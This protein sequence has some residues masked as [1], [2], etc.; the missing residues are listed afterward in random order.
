IGGS[1]TRYHIGCAR[2][3]GYQTDAHLSGSSGVGVR[4]MNQSLF[5][6]WQDDIDGSVSAQLIAQIDGGGSGI[7]EKLFHAFFLQCLYQQLISCNLF[8]SMNLPFSFPLPAAG[9]LKL[10]V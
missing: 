1:K 3:A 9:K 8:H 6:A 2:S 4:L 10:P 5:V 7:A